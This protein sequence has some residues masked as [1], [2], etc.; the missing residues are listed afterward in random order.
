MT[1]SQ[2]ETMKYTYNKMMLYFVS[3]LL[4]KAFLKNGGKIFSFLYQFYPQLIFDQINIDKDK[5][6]RLVVCNW[7]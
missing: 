7:H 3:I 1:Y 6:F 4:Y 2:K 5:T